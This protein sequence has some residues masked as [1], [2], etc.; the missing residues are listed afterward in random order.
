MHGIANHF[1]VS[2]KSLFTQVSILGHS[3]QPHWS[4]GISL[5]SSIYLQININ[6]EHTHKYLLKGGVGNHN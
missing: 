6:T 4:N 5:S 1:T 3:N 2:T